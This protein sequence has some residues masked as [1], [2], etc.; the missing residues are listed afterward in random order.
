MS[1]ESPASQ[2]SS[3][4]PTANMDRS[5]KR[6]R[7]DEESAADLPQRLNPKRARLSH[8]IDS[9]D[10]IGTRQQAVSEKLDLFKQK[11]TKIW[12]EN[13]AKVI[14]LKRAAD[15]M[16]QY[17][18]NGVEMVK[19]IN[20]LLEDFIAITDDVSEITLDAADVLNQWPPVYPGWLHPFDTDH[21]DNAQVNELKVALAAV[22]EK[23]NM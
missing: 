4:D 1:E 15:D 23:F 6:T 18:I 19:S 7:N 17:L 9:M 22:R 13:Y 8:L 20:T 5:N 16:Q 21:L 2:S 14:R 3:N 11:G 10:E 12:R